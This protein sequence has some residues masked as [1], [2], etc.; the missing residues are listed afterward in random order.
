MAYQQS[1]GMGGAPPH[2]GSEHAPQGTE[3]TLQGWWWHIR[4]GRLQARVYPRSMLTNAVGVMRFLQIEWHNHERA[5]NSW[6]IE[7]A[8]MKAKI[9]KQEGEVRHTKKL[10]EQ[11]ERQIKMLELALRNERSRK[12]D[13]AAEQ[14]RTETPGAEQDTNP[15]LKRADAATKGPSTPA[16]RTRAHHLVWR[17]SFAD[18]LHSSNCTT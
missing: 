8:E 9:A 2:G 5:R 1:A 17:I 7:R 4:P 12:R 10:N 15:S 14:A 6:D 18:S 3:Y 13:S 11:L 16:K